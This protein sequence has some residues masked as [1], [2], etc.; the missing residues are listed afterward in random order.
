MAMMAS[1]GV[2]DDASASEVA[3]VTRSVARRNAASRIATLLGKC[4]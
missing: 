4:R 2:V 3:V 1:R